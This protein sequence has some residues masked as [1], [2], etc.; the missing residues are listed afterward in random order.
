MF[1]FRFS[2]GCVFSDDSCLFLCAQRMVS[3]RL[4]H[5]CG[6]DYRKVFYPGLP[7]EAGALKSEL[8]AQRVN[9]PRGLRE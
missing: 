4:R 6:T 5:R 2:R 8:V 1:Q 7:F 3:L 9:M